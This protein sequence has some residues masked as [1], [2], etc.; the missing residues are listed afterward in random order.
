MSSLNITTLVTAYSD[1]LSASAPLRKN[2]DWNRSTQALQVTNPISTSYTIP[3]SQSLTVFSTVEATG[4]DGT[5]AFAVTLSPLSVNIYRFTS[6]AGTSPAFRTSRSINVATHAVTVIVNTNASATFNVAGGA[7]TGVVAGDIVF[8][9][10]LTTGDVAGAF[11]ALNEGFWVVNGVLSSTSL[12]LV[13]P[14]GVTFTVYGQVVTPAAGQFLAFSSAG[15]QTGDS[16]QITAGFAL[17]TQSTFIVGNVTPLWFEVVSAVALPLE[18]GILPTASGM[19][20]YSAAKRWFRVEADQLT[21]VKVNGDTSSFNQVMP[22]VAGDPA[23]V[24]WFDKWGPAFQLVLVN[25]SLVNCNV[26]VFSCE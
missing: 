7:Y 5:T 6:T 21:T 26:T 1:P 25:K 17:T 16:V 12:N 13:R 3:G 14:S 15:V 9:P 11:N 10:G 19:L 2:F 24:G 4:I 18:T 8:I 23:F 22:I 20:F